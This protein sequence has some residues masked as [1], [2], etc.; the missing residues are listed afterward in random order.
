MAF[1]C[2]HGSWIWIDVV[3]EWGQWR[4][5]VNAEGGSGLIGTGSGISL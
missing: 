3:Q 5:I 4:F 2:K 1:L